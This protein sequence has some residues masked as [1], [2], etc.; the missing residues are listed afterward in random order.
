MAKKVTPKSQREISI[1]QQTPYTGVNPN[2]VTFDLKNRGNQLS[3][4]DDDV[5]SFEL[6][7]KEID[8]VL[9]YYV[10]NVIKPSIIQ[11]G[12]I[13]K[14]PLIYG[15]GE[16]WDQFQKKGYLKDKSNKIMLP[17]MVYKRESIEKNRS[18]SNKLD[19]NA[20]SNLQVF[21]KSYSSK[22][23]YDKF[24]I[25]NNAV[26]TKKYYATVVP[27]YVNITYDFSIGTY[28]I[29]QLNKLI[30]D[31]NYASDSYWG[32]PESFK[33]RARID[34]FSTPVEISEGG[35]RRVRATFKLKLYGYIV[36][37]N[38]QQELS[39]LKKWNS[40]SRIIFDVE[41]VDQLSTEEIQSPSP[42]KST[43]LTNSK[44]ITQSL[45]TRYNY[46]I[47]TQTTS[48]YYGDEGWQL[49]NV[50]APIYSQSVI[51]DFRKVDLLDF[52]TL[53]SP[54]IFGNTERFTNSTGGTLVDDISFMSPIDITYDHYLGLQYINATIPNLSWEDSLEAVAAYDDGSWNIPPLSLMVQLIDFQW[55]DDNRVLNKKMGI[56]NLNWTSTTKPY[57]TT[58]AWTIRANFNQISVSLKSSTTLEAELVYRPI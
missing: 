11:N 50:W 53:S 52:Y 9:K 27:D 34:N 5:K 37:S 6:G 55:I 36:P 24:N 3:S 39:T 14:V 26:P 29:E 18:I 19:S 40:K 4:K 35:E 58:I 28:Y 32:D 13:Q 45:E 47:L 46:P 54:N 7:F 56:S 57:A 1:S 25:L 30:E 51:Q 2:D 8:E 42:S 15:S 49:E 31:M 21:E 22:N 43:F 10:D 20:P 23:R 38:I 16:R 48:Y 44:T 33:F 12:T 41:V 17:L